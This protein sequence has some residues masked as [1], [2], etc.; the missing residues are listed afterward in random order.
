MENK[1]K[2]LEEAAGLASET[3]R[4]LAEA[5]EQ[6]QSALN[7]MEGY[8][9]RTS[10]R[11]QAQER[12]AKN[13]PSCR[14]CLIQCASRFKLLSDMEK[15]Y[16]GYIPTPLRPYAGKP[17]AHPTT[18]Y[19][20]PVASLIKTEERFRRRGREPRLGYAMQKHS[21]GNQ[22]RRKGRH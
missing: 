12:R 21:C 11:R 5:E 2:Q 6:K 13:G 20:G 1:K 19:A 9:L 10:A 8:K 18:T 22:W 4:R 7:V 16:E 3:G 15:E 14:Y 17:K